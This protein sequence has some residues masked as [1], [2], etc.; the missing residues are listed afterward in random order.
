LI[1]FWLGGESEK[2][3]I[4]VLVK[5]VNHSMKSENLETTEW[6]KTMYNEIG[7][8]CN[9]KEEESK[10][11]RRGRHICLLNQQRTDRISLMRKSLRQ[12]IPQLMRRLIA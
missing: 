6:M 5:V 10:E 1:R 4:V 7:A 11:V 9:E 2:K 3:N 12:A 8:T